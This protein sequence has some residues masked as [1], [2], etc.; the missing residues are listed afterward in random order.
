MLVVLL[1]ESVALSML[2]VA[3]VRVVSRQTAPIVR[4]PLA[5]MFSEARFHVL[6]LRDG[7]TIHSGDDEYVAKREWNKVKGTVGHFEY[8]DAQSPRRPRGVW[9]KN[10]GLTNRENSPRV[11][12]P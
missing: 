4:P 9:V 6:S 12:L 8:W 2:S 1:I 11:S 3:F 5:P 10:P 7:S